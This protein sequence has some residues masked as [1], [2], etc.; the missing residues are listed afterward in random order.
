MRGLL[1]FAIGITVLTVAGRAGASNG[2]A[3]SACARWDVSPI[4]WEK[5]WRVTDDFDERMAANVQGIPQGTS[6]SHADA[7]DWR[8]S[9]ARSS[10]CGRWR[11]TTP[12]RSAAAA[13]CAR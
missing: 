12:A 9:R 11:A 7:R 6:F 2:N 5:I 10:P 3:D 13:A 4:E 1:T 8:A